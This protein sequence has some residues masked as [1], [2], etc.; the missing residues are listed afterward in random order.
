M[1][2]LTLATDMAGGLVAAVSASMTTLMETHAVPV[3]S[4]Q[5]GPFNPTAI[6]AAKLVKRI[7]NL[8]FMEMAEVSV[9]DNMYKMSGQS[10]ARLPITDISC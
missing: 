3:A 4:T 9:D 5:S 6:L 7:V 10:P 1:L 2:C 8:E